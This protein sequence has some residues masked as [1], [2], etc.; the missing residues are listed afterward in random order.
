MG[1]LTVKE[2]D[3]LERAIVDASRVSIFRRGTE[4]LV[5]PERLVTHNG[6]EAIQARHPTTGARLV[7]R[8]D[9]AERIEVVR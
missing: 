9:E 6:A 4:Y 7:L 3:V 2:Y 8:L 1:Q 5:I